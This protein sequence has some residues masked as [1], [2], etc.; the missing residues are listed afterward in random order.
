MASDENGAPNLQ[1]ILDWCREN[2][3][4]SVAYIEQAME[5][6]RR[7]P[8][9]GPGSAMLLLLALGFQAGRQ[10]Q[11]DHPEHGVHSYHTDPELLHRAPV[12]SEDIVR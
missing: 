1:A 8:G 7:T 6:D 11:I 9:D 12:R 2:K 5:L 10:Y 3:P 4:D